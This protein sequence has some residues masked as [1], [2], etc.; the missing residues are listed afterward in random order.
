MKAFLIVT[1]C[2]CAAIV[3]SACHAGLDLG[4]N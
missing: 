1:L 3:L 4:V 2:G